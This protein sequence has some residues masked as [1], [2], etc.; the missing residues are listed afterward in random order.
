MSAAPRGIL[1]TGAA[2]VATLAGGLRR[3]GAQDDPAIAPPG[4]AVACLGGLSVAV[5]A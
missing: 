4:T 5:A 1:V 2:E 3:G